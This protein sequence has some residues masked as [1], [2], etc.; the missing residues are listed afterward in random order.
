MRMTYL[1]PGSFLLVALM[2]STG[3][4]RGDTIPNLSPLLD[5]YAKAWNT[6]EVET[7]D[8]IADSLFV[9]YMSPHCGPVVGLDTLKAIILHTRA[10]YPDFTLRPDEIIFTLDAAAV[11]WTAT[12][13]HS[14]RNAP[15]LAGKKVHVPG[16]SLV[17][18][19]DGKV[20]DEWIQTNDRAWME[21]LGFEFS[22]RDSGTV[23]SK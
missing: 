8:A 13:T 11:R 18:F 15:S 2:L 4:Q 3:C 16:M 17:H 10:M 22:P 20:V 23:G 5:E 14:G 21:Q 6:G 1:V 7:L 12:A 9:L 19:R